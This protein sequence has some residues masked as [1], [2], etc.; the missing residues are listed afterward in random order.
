MKAPWSEV[1]G[2]LFE[3]NNKL[4]L[5]MRS[6][7]FFR[8]KTPPCCTLRRFW[9]FYLNQINFSP[10]AVP[11]K[12]DIF[13]KPVITLSWRVLFESN[14]MHLPKLDHEKL[15]IQSETF[16]CISSTR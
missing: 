2:I 14:K 7:F 16:Y 4:V 12:I 5:Q 13:W 6:D 9:F 15:D 1:K 10:A 11:A 3:S 8:Y